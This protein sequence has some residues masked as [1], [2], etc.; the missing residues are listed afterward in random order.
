[1]ILNRKTLIFI[2]KIIFSF[3]I[4]GIM[5]I[6]VDLR[7]LAESISRVEIP[8]F[9]LSIFLVIFIQPIRSYRWGL[10]LWKRGVN[11]PFWSLLKLYFIGLFFST[12]LPTIVGGDVVRGYYL[13][14]Y[15]KEKS[16]AIASI[17]IDRI[18]G[19]Y[20]L[21]IMSFMASL[22]SIERFYEVRIFPAIGITSVIILVLLSMIFSPGISRIVIFPFRSLKL[23][24]MREKVE[25]LKDAMNIYWKDKI[26]IA[27]ILA[28]SIIF[29]GIFV[30]IIYLLSISLGW[31]FS[32]VDFFILI[33]MVILI[34]MFPLSLS[35]LGAREGALAF[36]M[37]FMGVDVHE[38]LSLS[39]LWFSLTLISG[40]LGGV[41]YL[42]MRRSR[43]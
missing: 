10:L 12:F 23:W 13:F 39:A 38:A 37:S 43:S 17:I 7:G 20:A 26:L 18:S 28:L 8:W 32:P 41:F 29:N 33:P 36:F 11:V 2:L 6:S 25:R 3:G 35:G 40:L 31:R 16:K 1:L 42:F 30:F 9:C 34:S 14:N 4:V 19:V 27:Y 24:Q 15:T 21:A 22:I 5:L